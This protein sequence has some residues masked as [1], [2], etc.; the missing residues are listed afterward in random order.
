MDRRAPLS[1]EELDQIEWEGS[2]P[3]PVQALLLTGCAVLFAAF[4]I[5]AGLGFLA[6]LV[7][8]AIEVG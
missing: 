1:E 8:A 7:Q 3:R 6:L 2:R 5:L 4:W